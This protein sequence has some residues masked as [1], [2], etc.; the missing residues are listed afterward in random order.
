M[1]PS[2]L[3]L[4]PVLL[5]GPV[6]AQ[7]TLTLTVAGSTTAR[8][9]AEREYGFAAYPV[10][11][12]APL[13]IEV[14][15]RIE[16]TTRQ[17]RIEV[18]VLGLTLWFRPGYS[19]FADNGLL[20]SLQDRA[21]V[22]N[23]ML[24]L[25][26]YFYAE[27]LPNRHP[28][29]LR[30][31]A[32]T[33]TLEQVAN[34]M[35]EPLRAAYPL[36]VPAGK[37][38]PKAVAQPGRDSGAS[39]PVGGNGSSAITT[40]FTEEEPRVASAALDTRRAPSPGPSPS[41]EMHMRLS[42]FYSDNFFQAP[43]G[44]APAQLLA[45]SADARVVLRIPEQRTNVQARIGRTLFDGFAPSTAVTGGFDANGKYHVVE[46][47][48]GYQRRSPRLG[49]GDQPGFASSVYASGAFGMK[50]PLQM[51]V[52]ALGHY[53]DIYLHARATDS[54]F[55]GA[56]GALR[57]RGFGY[58]FS[59]EVGEVRSTWSSSIASENY[60]ERAQWVSVRAVPV[61]PVWLHAR[62]RRD[63]RHYT[64][65]DESSSNFGRA[66][67]REVWTLATDVRLGG[68]LTWGMYYTLEDG[69]SSRTDRTF[70][71]QSITSGLS[72]RVW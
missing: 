56:G 47:T 23:G 10:T 72:Y 12:L 2:R 21:F 71:T 17:E 51:Q 60:R 50:L 64:I 55:S 53:Y 61:D 35:A 28:R 27:W 1:I 34:V 65:P 14:T 70:R 26:E 54:R 33:R 22:R 46:A 25:P 38:E 48:G 16:V 44:A 68:R 62:Y 42:G 5:A 3:F 49:V 24:Y 11:V 20:V 39:T 41:V 19:T 57:Y 18:K 9:A 36:P 69:T 31:T 30:Y 52:S 29:G 7:S 67:A 32:A 58:R 8:A 45:T 63:N 43:P 13:G 37:L 66:D 6:S 59:P 4:L 15:R 40:T